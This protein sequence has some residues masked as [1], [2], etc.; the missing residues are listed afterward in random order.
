MTGNSLGFGRWLRWGFV[1]LGIF[2]SGCLPI[3]DRATT[4]KASEAVV[5]GFTLPPG[6]AMANPRPWS[7]W[8]SSSSAAISARTP[9]YYRPAE[10]NG[11]AYTACG[12]HIDTTHLRVAADWTAF[13]AAKSYRHLMRGDT[14]FSFGMIADRSRH[15][16]HLTYPANWSSLVARA[17]RAG[18]RGRRP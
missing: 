17:A 6:C 9:Y 11:V 15:E 3:S 5:T 14:S 13:L 8:A 1:V 4:G 10:N 7:L 2:G 18:R 12:G 16:M